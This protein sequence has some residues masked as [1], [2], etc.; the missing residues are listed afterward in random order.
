LDGSEKIRYTEFLAATIEASGTINEVK[1]AEAFDR[2]DSDDSGFI[3][4]ENLLE[5]LGDTFTK[6]DVEAIIKEVTVTNGQISYSEFLSLWESTEDNNDD[7]DDEITEGIS[8]NGFVTSSIHAE[9]NGVIKTVQV[10]SSKNPFLDSERSTGAISTLSSDYDDSS[11][12]VAPKAT[13][14]SSINNT[15]NNDNVDDPGNISRVNFLQGKM[16]SERN[17]ILLHQAKKNSFVSVH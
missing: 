16:M 11:A 14:I 2:L 1:L 10:N 9:P 12:A 5:I 17:M 6:E 3:S 7:D 15:I 4:V 13:T 8:G